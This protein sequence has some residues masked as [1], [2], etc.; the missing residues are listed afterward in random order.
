MR[1]LFFLIF[2]LIFSGAGFICSAQ[3]EEFQEPWKNNS[4]AIVI[5]P[6]EKNPIDWDKLA[7]DPR[8]VGIVH[9]ATIGFRK[10][11]E[12]SDRREEAKRRGYKWGSYHLG[13]AGDPVKQADFYLK[14][15]NPAEDEVIA[16][17]LESLDSDRYMN[18]E[19]ART[20][21][22]RIKERTG[23]YPL[24]YGNYKVI[25]TIS[26]TIGKDDL[27]SRTPLWYARYRSEVTDFPMG[28]WETYTLWQF[29]CEINCRPSQPNN[30]PYLVPGTKS[31]MDVN[32]YNGTIDE[33]KN[34]WPFTRE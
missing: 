14:T 13:K 19:G 12:Y 2:S 24:I 8:V 22:R 9:R 7:T 25:N 27:F 18:L 20:F 4:I 30:C 21:I 10:D 5:D 1:R 31:D 11:K 6:Y 29:S 34:N 28:T 17:D 33:L 15:V 26:S 3:T 16:L 23:R 32:V